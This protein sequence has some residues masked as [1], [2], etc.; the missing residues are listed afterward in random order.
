MMAYRK[1]VLINPQA[2]CNVGSALPN[3][4]PTNHTNFM[5]SPAGATVPLKKEDHDPDFRRLFGE[6]YLCFAYR[7]LVPEDR[8][9]YYLYCMC[10]FLNAHAREAR[11]RTSLIHP[12]YIISGS[13]PVYLYHVFDR[14]KKS[15][16]EF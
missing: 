4:A 16:H 3:L 13:Y 11:T 6:D 10:R 12:R 1:H 14:N 2:F 7:Q 8:L 5:P 15:F 9:S